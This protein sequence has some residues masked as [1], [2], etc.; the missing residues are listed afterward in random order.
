MIIMMVRFDAFGVARTGVT[1]FTKL[2]DC[3]EYRLTGIT[4]SASPQISCV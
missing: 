4:H 3:C 2:H 1:I